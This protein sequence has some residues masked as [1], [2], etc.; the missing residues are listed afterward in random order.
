LYVN[1]F[2][3][4]KFSIDKFIFKRTFTARTKNNEV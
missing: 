2:K 3:K 4:I 1:A